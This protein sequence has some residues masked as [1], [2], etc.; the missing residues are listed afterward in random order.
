MSW[1]RPPSE[2]SREAVESNVTRDATE[3]P[4]TDTSGPSA[5]DTAPADAV[6]VAATVNSVF[7][8]ADTRQGEGGTA[9]VGTP[10]PTAF[11]PAS[12]AEDPMVARRAQASSTDGAAMSQA[13]SLPV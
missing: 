12:V 2:A 10:R 13:F 6:A 5:T 8:E 4:V 3:P 11:V 7:V 1:H 9:F